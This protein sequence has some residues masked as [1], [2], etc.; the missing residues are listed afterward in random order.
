MQIL[1][2]LAIGRGNAGHKG[3]DDIDAPTKSPFDGTTVQMR[4][5]FKSLHFNLSDLH[6]KRAKARPLGYQR[7][8]EYQVFHD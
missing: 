1:H 4:G 6:E 2:T 5:A 3:S 8:A 7:Q